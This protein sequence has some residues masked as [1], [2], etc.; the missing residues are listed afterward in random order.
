MISLVSIYSDERDLIVLL[1]FS[2]FIFIY[3]FFCVLRRDEMHV[4]YAINF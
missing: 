2:L 1:F 4:V 3:L